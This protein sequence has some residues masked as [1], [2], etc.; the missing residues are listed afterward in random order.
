MIHREL[1]VLL[2]TEV[3]DPRVADVTITDVDVTPDLLVA[4]VFYTVMGDQEQIDAAQAGLDRASGFLRT[5]LAG[6][7]LL[8]LAPK[9]IFEFDRSEVYGRHIEA[10]LD[11]IASEE[12]PAT[13]DQD[14]LDDD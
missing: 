13:P 3:H 8:R 10:L 12:R 6:R 5:Q 14:P 9:L 1:S 7:V 11:Q 4:R 2:M